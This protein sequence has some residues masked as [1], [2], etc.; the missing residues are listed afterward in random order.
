MKIN[1]QEITAKAFTYDN[2]H[3]I[4]I[5]EDNSDLLDAKVAGYDIYPIEYLPTAYETSCELRFISNWK[6]NKSY[7]AQFTDCVFSK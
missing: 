4:Y 6:L 7:V 1:G 3:K 2:C 5:I